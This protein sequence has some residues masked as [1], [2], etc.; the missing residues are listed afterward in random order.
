MTLL[1]QEIA[2]LDVSENEVSEGTFT[3]PK[4]TGIPSVPQKVAEILERRGV[5]GA[6]VRVI[7][8][9]PMPFTLESVGYVASYTAAKTAVTDY[10]GLIGKQYGVKLTKDSIEWGIFDVISVRESAPPQTVV[11]KISGVAGSN[12]VVRQVCVWTLLYRAEL[13]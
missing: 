4:L 10:Q 6:G 8:Q 7:G 9:K 1:T 3:F 12:T 5:D 11:A 13:S 2:E